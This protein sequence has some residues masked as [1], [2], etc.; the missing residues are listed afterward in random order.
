MTKSKHKYRTREQWGEIQKLN[1]LECRTCKI[2]K[3]LS[4]FIERENTYPM[5]LTECRDCL[6]LREQTATLKRKQTRGLEW[7]IKK[8]IVRIKRR[9]KSKEIEF[10]LDIDYLV[11]LWNKQNG[12]CWYTKR[13]MNFTTHSP[14][15]FSLDRKDSNLGYTKDNVIWCCWTVNDIKADISIKDLS[16]ILTDIC[17]YNL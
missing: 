10:D 6:N 15:L 13:E 8:Y 2:T 11:S 7:N 17:R 5:W 16:E 12:L 3:S 1:K 14:E 4:N 9:A